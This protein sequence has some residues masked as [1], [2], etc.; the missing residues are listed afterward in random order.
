VSTL[1]I[2]EDQADILASL[3]RLKGHGTVG[4]VVSDSGLAADNVRVALKGL[5]ESHRGHLDVSDSGELLYRFDEKLITRGT[6]PVLARMKRQTTSVLTAGFKA[7]IV[8]MLVVY[9]LIFVA[10]V[11]AALL[12]NKNSDSRGGGLGGRRGGGGGHRHFPMGNFWLWYYIWT[13]RWR[14]GRPYYGHR[15]E[16]QLH[17]DDRSPFYKKVFAF[18]FGPDKPQPTQN[19]LDRGT[20]RLIRARSGVITTAELVEHTGLPV[21]EAEDEMGRLLGAYDGEAVVSPDGELV[22]AFPSVMVSTHEASTKEPHPAWLRLEP[23]QELTGNT[24][25]NNAIVV[26]MNAFTLAAA[27]TSPWFIFPRLGIGGPA[28]YVGLVLVPVVFS[29]LFFAVPGLRMW[30][31]KRENKR[32]IARN[33][34]KVLLGLV[35]SRALGGNAE[36]RSDEVGFYVAERMKGVDA[37][38]IDRAVDDLA[39]EFDADVSVD[40]AGVTR[41]QFPAIREQFTASETV[42]RK[43]Q[44]EKR[45]LGEVVFSTGDSAVEA[46]DRDLKLFDRELSRDEARFDKYL[47]A[48]DRVGYED[49]FD[50]VAFDEELRSRG[51]A[52]A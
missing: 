29:A 8:I 37:K 41:F 32:R 52:K 49:D 2:A 9:F 46:G 44:L 25:K 45:S 39:A 4:D 16:S 14:I 42:R 7:T 40:E 3:R 6:E 27:V 28:A 19:Q 36:V 11:I 33:I 22:Y 21:D 38:A 15:W 50:L 47:P 34:R 20:L 10:L 12:A 23:Q 17:K 13:P 24:A 31:V 30:G 48:T 5:L 35:Y 26:G 18:V 1:A 51:L 43:L